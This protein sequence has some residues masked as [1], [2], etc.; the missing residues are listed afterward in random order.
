MADLTDKQREAIYYAQEGHNI[1]VLGQS[2]TGKSAV[3]K[4]LYKIMDGKLKIP[5][6]AST[7]L[8]ATQFK[9]IGGQ[10]A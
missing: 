8:A 1:A 5:V 2:G 4:K 9:E 3:I 7:G 10:T 6:T